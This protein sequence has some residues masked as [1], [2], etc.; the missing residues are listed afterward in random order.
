MRWA[1]GPA[2]IRFAMTLAKYA[3]PFAGSM[4]ARLMAVIISTFKSQ[5]YWTVYHNQRHVL[6]PDASISTLRRNTRQVFF[7]NFRT[8]YRLWHT[9]SR[10]KEAIRHAVHIQP[11]IWDSLAQARARNQGVII[12]GCHTGS[13][14]LSGMALVANGLEALVLSLGDAPTGGFDVMD[15]MRRRVGLELAPISVK[16]LRQAI[17]RLRG[18][19]VV[20]TGIDRPLGNEK[21]D[22][23]FFGSP[24]LLPTGMVRIAMKTKSSII[25]TSAY[26]NADGESIIHFSPL[27]DIDPQ[28]DLA[29]NMGHVVTWMEK[30]IATYPDQWF[31]FFPVWPDHT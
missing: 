31:M 29:H 14:D 30:F 19:G 20:I 24:S 10:D 6:G 11:D 22:V 15:D 28:A 3:P 5:V 2:F 26:R 18:G 17:Q 4:L 21:P 16:A 25:V 23:P 27:I 9:I 1:S 7:N 13:F 8:L 12:G